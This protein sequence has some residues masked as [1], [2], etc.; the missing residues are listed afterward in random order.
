MYNAY[1]KQ[2]WGLG[3]VVE[4]VSLVADRKRLLAFVK[5]K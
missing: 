1:E 4:N 5:S 3:P 2:L